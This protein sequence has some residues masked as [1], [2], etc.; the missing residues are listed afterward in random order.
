MKTYCTAQ[1][2]L[3]NVLWGPKWEG[4]PEKR[5]Y[6]RTYGDS[7]CFVAETDRTLYSD[8]APIP[9]FFFFSKKEETLHSLMSEE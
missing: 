6:V 1:R 5:R 2:T 8:Y 3:L 9:V 7:L 4:N